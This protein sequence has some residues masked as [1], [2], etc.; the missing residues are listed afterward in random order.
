MPIYFLS[1]SE[2]SI[3][4]HTGKLYQSVT[5]QA[6]Q[7]IMKLPI[8][9]VRNVSCWKLNKQDEINYFDKTNQLENTVI[10]L[11]SEKILV[12]K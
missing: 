6:L 7:T 10:I 1:L 5:N 12:Y 11:S 9:H 2:K 8:E 3:L 4:V